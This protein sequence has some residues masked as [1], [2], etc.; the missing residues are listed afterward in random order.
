MSPTKQAFGRFIIAKRQA[1]GLTQRDLA[2]RLFVTESAVS[3]WERGLSYP[4]ITLVESLS[5]ELGV[6]EGE[7]I[8]ASD[9]HVSR[10]IARDALGYRRWKAAI[11]WTTSIAYAAAL[12][13]CF[14]VNL[15]VAHTLSWFWIVVA[16]LA[17]AFS[18]TTLPLLRVRPKGWIALGAFVVSIALLL[19]VV[20]LESGRGTW[21]PIPITAILFAVVV[22]FGPI[23]LAGLSLPSPASLHRTV[24]A[25]G[26]DTIALAVLLLV[27]TSNP[28]LW[29]TQALPIAAIALVIP[30]GAALVI[31]YVPLAALLRAAI[32]IAF[33][34]IY[35][36]MLL[37]PAIA[38]VDHDTQPRP[39]DFSQW[40]DIYIGENVS[41]LVLIGSL[42]V[43]AILA[44]TAAVRHQTGSGGRGSA[45]DTRI[46][47]TQ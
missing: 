38:W 30:W 3:K 8:N 46:R 43:A 20:W 21:L 33:V 22:I 14:I 41:V 45:K 35:S 27:A 36:T 4:D 23:W 18:L 29:L 44:I 11:F 26:L 12:V 1:V 25:L 7:L 28:I 6:S 32:V 9:D 42:L 17:A 47:A 13:T 24:T 31:R 15:S 5:R 40:H 37:Q 34:S 39:V 19:T 2:E 10:D 16:A